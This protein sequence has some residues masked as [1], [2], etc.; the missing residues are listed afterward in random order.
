MVGEQ[1]ATDGRA[2]CSGWVKALSEVIK[3]A[4][5]PWV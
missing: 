5:V 3:E 4:P 1:D 2:L